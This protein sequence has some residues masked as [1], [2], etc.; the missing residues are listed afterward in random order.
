MASAST[1]VVAVLISLA[2]MAVSANARFRAM[3][4]TSAHATFY[5]DETAAETMGGACGYGNLYN[6]GY[7]TDTAALSTT[8][9][10][11]GYGCGTCY[12]MRCTGSPSCL[13]GSPVITVT[14]TNLCPPNWAQD[15]NNGGWCNPPRTHFDLSKPAFM[16]MAEWRAGIVPVMYRRVPCVRK[17][18]IRFALQGNAYWL[19]AYV[20]NVAGAGDVGE[21]WVKSGGSTGWIRMSHNWGASYQAFAQLGGQPL[22]FKLTSYTTK[23]TI[24]ATDVTPA[25][26]CV[27]LTYEARINF[28]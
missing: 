14:A 16:K 20:T 22:S 2:S 28:S 1:V 10:Q 11:D 25:N 4:W 6:T 24:V 15:S 7:G 3:Q 27:G 19:L 17:G 9:F 21:M 18:G 5:G 12:Q 23:Q 8:L 13:R 26:W